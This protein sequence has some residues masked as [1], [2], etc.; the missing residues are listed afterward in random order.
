VSFPSV[1]GGF[2]YNEVKEM[3][4]IIGSTPNISG[5]EISEFNPAVEM[6]Q[7]LPALTNWVYSYYCGFSTLA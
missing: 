4:H 3:M 2:T 1:V 6:V 5:L 7:S